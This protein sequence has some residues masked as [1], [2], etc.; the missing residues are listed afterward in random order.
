[1]IRTALALTLA[2][3]AT[4]APLAAQAAPREVVAFPG[5]EGAGRFSTGGR[6]GAVIHV[7]NLNDDGPGSL[8]AAIEAK[9]PRT[10]VFDVAGTIQLK[11]ELKISNGQ[12]TIAGQTAPGG[13]IT[14]R[15]QT[16]VVS[17][18]DVII[19]FIRSRLGS[20]SKVEGDAIWIS[21]GRRIILDHVSA[22]W[23]R[24]SLLGLAGMLAVALAT[25]GSIALA[26]QGDVDG[27]SHS[28]TIISSDQN[29]QYVDIESDK[30]TIANNGT[31][32]SKLSIYEGKVEIRGRIRTPETLVLLNG[33]TPPVGFDATAV[34]PSQIRRLE[35]T[36]REGDAKPNLILNI[37]TTMKP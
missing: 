24:R 34:P 31:A 29:A 13:G 35:V 20:E 10:V 27:A 17:A 19:R 2:L 6:G 5:A 28:R 30:V 14:L 9:G 37:I 15:D 32:N 11:K 16:L 12:I 25:A 1:M 18:D 8:R 7:T 21:G 22:S 26:Q 33:A 3:T 36:N 4:A 23:M